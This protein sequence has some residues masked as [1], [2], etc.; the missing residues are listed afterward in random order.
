MTKE[1]SWVDPRDA[2]WKPKCWQECKGDEVP[3]GWEIAYDEAVG[4]YFIDHLNKRNLLDDPR[5]NKPKE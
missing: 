5:D 2:L 3:Y 4:R 1:T